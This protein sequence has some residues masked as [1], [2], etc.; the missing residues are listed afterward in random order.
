M[1]DNMNFQEAYNYIISEKKFPD[2]YRPATSPA[3]RLENFK[4]F[5]NILGNPENKIPHYIH[6]TGTSGKGSTCLMLAS[7]LSN[8]GKKV[9]LM[10]SPHLT[11]ITERWQINNQ[12]MTEKEFIRIVKIIKEKMNGHRLSFFELTT[13]IGL[14]YFA[15][16]KVDWAIIEV[17]CGGRYD[18]TNAIPHKDAAVITNIGLDHTEILGKTKT[19]ITYEKSGII[20]PGCKVFTSEKNKGLLKIINQECKKNNTPLIKTVGA[21]ILHQTNNGTTFVYK[22]K[23]YRLNVLGKHQVDNAT[24]AI[25]TANSLN[26]GYAQ[27]KNGLADVRLPVRLEII[28]RKPLVILDGAHNAD[29]TKATTQAIKQLKADG[30]ISRIHLLI[31]FSANKSQATIKELLKLQPATLACTRQTI[32]PFRLAMSPE[33]IRSQFTS[34]NIKTFNSPKQALVWSKKQ[35]L[36]DDLLLI[37]GSMFLAGE[38]RQYFKSKKV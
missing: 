11:N 6:V 28:S 17:G 25:A 35:L 16:K 12:T 19:K 7:I 5:L 37:T 30:Y 23:K 36:P 26:L 20:K 29:E 4:L 3:Q 27:I 33:D 10:T 13:A 22:N 15:E 31:G 9:G 8:S 18:S 2:N 32:N 38:L 14:L 1:S 21:K 24:L 34:P